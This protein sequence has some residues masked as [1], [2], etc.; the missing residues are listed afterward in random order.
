M[1]AVI[2]NGNSINPG[3]VSWEPVTSLADTVI[4]PDTADDE[5]I[6]RARG[7][8]GILTDRT[9]IDRNTMENLP[10]LK[11]ILKL[12]TG[13][14]NIDL[15]CAQELGIRVFNIPAYSTDAVAQHTFAL[16]LGIAN[17]VSRLDRMIADE[18]W[19]EARASVY[20]TNPITLLAGK[21]I[22]IVGYGNIGSKVGEIAEAFGM[23]VNIYSRNRQAA[24]SSDFVSLHCPLNKDTAKLVNREF[25]SEMKDGAYL[26]NTS[27]GGLV[28]EDALH[29]A[30]VSGKLAGA[31]LDVAADE[32]APYDPVIHLPNVLM[33]P[34][35]AF[36]PKETR[37]SI[38]RICRENIGAFLEGRNN[39]RIV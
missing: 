32:P 13:Y 35:I 26:I 21:S 11:F 30:L 14:D 3:D 23:R 18:G 16:I 17:H 25:I 6:E 33:T 20:S 39:N 28:D 27:R 2:F 38:I 31:G 19:T 36:A 15:K 8:D 9:G 22:G 4:Y 34:H 37:A 1:K 5:R 24:V 29:D 12:A 10:D 7:F